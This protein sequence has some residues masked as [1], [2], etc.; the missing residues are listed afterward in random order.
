MQ[1]SHFIPVR[2]RREFLAKAGLGFGG[3]ALA[4]MIAEEEAR[5]E[6][7]EIDPL[8]PVARRAP[9]HEAKAKACIFLFMEGGPSHIDLFDP[10]PAIKRHEVSR[11]RRVS[12]RCSRRWESAATR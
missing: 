9:H 12:E 8:R 10:K 4:S 6:A 5:A 11:C 7:P 1:S 2:S 3:L